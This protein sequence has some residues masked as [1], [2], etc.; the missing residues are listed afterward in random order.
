M[1]KVGRLLAKRRGLTSRTWIPFC[2]WL[3]PKV[4]CAIVLAAGWLEDCIDRPIDV[5]MPGMDGKVVQLHLLGVRPELAHSRENS[6]IDMAIQEL[7]KRE[8][9]KRAALGSKKKRKRQGKGKIPVLVNMSKSRAL[10]EI[11]EE[12]LLTESDESDG[13][14]RPLRLASRRLQSEEEQMLHAARHPDSS[15][16][17]IGRSQMSIGCV[18]SE[19]GVVETEEEYDDAVRD[20]LLGF[21]VKLARD[22]QIRESQQLIQRPTFELGLPDWLWEWWLRRTRTSEQIEELRTGALEQIQRA[23]G[24]ESELERLLRLTQAVDDVDSDS[25]AR[26]KLLSQYCTTPADA[27]RLAMATVTFEKPRIAIGLLSPLECL[28]RVLRALVVRNDPLSAALRPWPVRW[29]F[30]VQFAQREEAA[31][32]RHAVNMAVFATSILDAERVLVVASQTDVEVLRDG[33]L[34]GG[35]WG[36]A[37][38]Q[39]GILWQEILNAA[40][41]DTNHVVCDDDGYFLKA[42]SSTDRRDVLFCDV[43]HSGCVVRPVKDC[44]NVGSVLL[45]GCG[46]FTKQECGPRGRSGEYK[47]SLNAFNASGSA[48]RA[49]Y[50]A[51]RTR[52]Q[53]LTIK[54]EYV[55]ELI[56]QFK[57]IS[58]SMPSSSLP[59]P[60]P[61]PAKN[62]TGLHRRRQSRYGRAGG[63]AGKAGRIRAT[64]TKQ[65]SLARSQSKSRNEPCPCGSGK[66]FKHCCLN[67]L[68]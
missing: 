28:K 6:D 43:S 47:H 36:A 26:A 54:P 64:K 57:L 25:G 17:F 52:N 49:Q 66:K 12:V 27:Q 14:I 13:R 44:V 51:G 68:K 20:P 61:P 32:V 40:L 42:G 11:A 21:Q 15:A 53:V 62:A 1:Q 37:R 46:R 7:Q 41:S 33:I 23:S 67:K 22:I 59:P 56:G 38:S 4:K 60:P 55:N 5:S 29:E 3:Y 19:P 24:L 39:D 65:M 18:L 58:T 8:K 9:R 16:F 34:A 31:R 45:D 63:V 48:A 30:P 35:D 50:R 2:F 10:R